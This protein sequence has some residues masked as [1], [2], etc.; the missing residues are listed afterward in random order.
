[1]IVQLE[2]QAQAACI[3]KQS[4]RES[5]DHGD[6]FGRIRGECRLWVGEGGREGKEGWLPG[7]RSAK[8]DVFTAAAA[9]L[10][11][12]M[13]RWLVQRWMQQRQ[14]ETVAV[15]TWPSRAD[16]GEVSERDQEGRRLG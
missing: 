5:S 13:V 14:R 16:E 11:G 12:E 4:Q 8:A 9:R 3:Q 15:H 2:A 1:M 7:C 10:E 6:F